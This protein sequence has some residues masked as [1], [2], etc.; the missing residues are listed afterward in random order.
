MQSPFD[1]RQY[2]ATRTKGSMSTAKRNE[3]EI[4]RNASQFKQIK[5]EPG[6]VVIDC[7]DD[8]AMYTPT[9]HTR[10]Y[11]PTP[12]RNETTEITLRRPPIALTTLT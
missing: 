8:T 6:T 7:D 9:T 1:H 4:T 11:R 2:T 3:H 10:T 12:S 5:L